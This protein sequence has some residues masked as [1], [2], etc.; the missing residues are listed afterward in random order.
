MRTS[1]RPFIPIVSR[2]KT[3]IHLEAN[4]ILVLGAC[5]TSGGHWIQKMEILMKPPPNYLAYLYLE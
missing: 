1:W 3:N 5:D 4:V 2:D